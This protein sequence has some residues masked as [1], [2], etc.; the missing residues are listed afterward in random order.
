M[1]TWNGNG[2]IS[3]AHED[4]AM[5]APFPWRIILFMLLLVQPATL[6]GQTPRRWRSTG[7]DAPPVTPAPDPR[8]LRAARE[9]AVEKVGAGGRE[10]VET[11]GEDAVAAICV[12]SRT[13]S[14]QLVEFHSS[15]GLGKLPRPRELLRVVGKPNHGDDVASWAIAHAGELADVDRFEAYLR[16]PLSYA[17]A[18]KKLDDGAAEVGRFRRYVSDYQ[19]QTAQWASRSS[20]GWRILGLGGGVTAIVLLLRWRKR[21]RRA[22]DPTA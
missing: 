12:C 11:Y 10:F 19:A 18:L 13:V 22:L 16:D 17:L 14:L 9:R 5:T 3:F 21:Q 6:F 20:H 2:K 1:A 7:P 8:E 15:G 4:K